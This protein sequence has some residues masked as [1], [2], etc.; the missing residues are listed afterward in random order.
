[1]R[2]M[3]FVAFAVLLAVSLAGCTIFR[4]PG[5]TVHG[6]VLL[7]GGAPAANAKITFTPASAYGSSI[8]GYAAADGTWTT[9]RFGVK[10]DAY[11]IKFE[12]PDA[13]Q[14]STI[15]YKICLPF[16]P[17]DVGIVY[18]WGEEATDMVKVTGVVV[19]NLSVP[20][21]N[22][23]VSFVYQ[24]TPAYVLIVLTNAAGE[25]EV[26]GMLAGTYDINISKVGYTDTF[27]DNE[28]LS[29]PENDLGDITLNP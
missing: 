19:D 29:N 2:K 3:L 11:T 8:T 26:P 4:M 27:I 1:M 23:A 15:S 6:T 9:E 13:G 12:H 25:F 5:A 14:P 22:A 17:Y 7:D 21:A 16:K 24:G 20:V 10:P 18:L 28:D